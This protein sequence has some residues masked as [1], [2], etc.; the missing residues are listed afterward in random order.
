MHAAVLNNGRPV[1]VKVQHLGI[2]QTVQTDLDLMEQVADLIN[3]YASDLPY[4]PRT[5][6][7]EFQRQLLREMDLRQEARNLTRFIKNFQNEPSVK[8]PQPDAELSTSLVL[9]MER[10]EGYKV[11]DVDLLREAGIDTRE[12]SKEGA[13]IWMEMIFRDGFFHADPHPGNFLVLADGRIGLLDCGM[14]GRIDEQHAVADLEEL[15]LVFVAKDV[16]GIV[17]VILLFVP[18]PDVST[19]A[20]FT[21]AVDLFIA[22]YL[23]Q[24]VNELDM[25]GMLT[26]LAGIVH[27]FHVIMPSSIIMLGK[28]IALLEGTGRL[29]NPDFNLAELAAPYYATIIQRRYAPEKLMRHLVRAYRDWR[30]LIT[31]LPRDLAE[32]LTDVRDGQLQVQFEV[33]GLD[34]VVN[35]LVYGV[36][37]MA[38]ILASA[39]LWSADVPPHLGNVSIVGALGMLLGILIAFQLLFAIYR[40]GGL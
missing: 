1:V 7:D 14:V 11:A 26:A 40:S 12:L 8:I 20:P 13:N 3:R 15:L 32:L 30:R 34:R 19:A 16:D 35:R 6:V 37:A 21:A 27:K 17:D 25:S 29:L 18:C 28:T 31:T 22:D 38:L 33:R 2:E 5:L 9:T 36:I 10:L 23:D 39:M 4:D 24:S